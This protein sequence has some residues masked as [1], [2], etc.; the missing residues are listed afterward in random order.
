MYEYT[1]GYIAIWR[2]TEASVL[3]HRALQRLKYCVEKTKSAKV[4][5]ITIIVVIM[6]L[7]FHP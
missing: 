4:P 6:Q 3:L 7:S 1:D 2:A 5:A